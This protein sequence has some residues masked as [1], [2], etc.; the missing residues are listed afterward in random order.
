[1]LASKEEREEQSHDLVI[2]VNGAV[3]V[4]HVDENLRGSTVLAFV[5]RQHE[6]S[7][8]TLYRHLYTVS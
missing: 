6:R 5:I 1:M 7:R 2:R 4:L 8:Q 3:L